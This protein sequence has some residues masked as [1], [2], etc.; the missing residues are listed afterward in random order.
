MRYPNPDGTLDQEAGA[1]L[2]WGKARLRRQPPGIS[3][4]ESEQDVSLTRDGSS[5]ALGIQ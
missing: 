1:P 2:H 5:Q 3:G 4:W